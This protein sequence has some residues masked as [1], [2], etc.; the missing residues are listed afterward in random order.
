M[1][2]ADVTSRLAA[3]LAECRRGQAALERQ[4]AQ[5][6]STLAA[7]ETQIALLMEQL[8]ATGQALE[9]TARRAMMAERANAA[10]EASLGLARSE[11]AM[12]RPERDA[13]RRAAWALTQQL[14]ALEGALATGWL[15]R[16]PARPAIGR[17]EGAIALTIALGLRRTEL[18]AV[19]QMVRAQAARTPLL[20]V[21]DRDL[22]ASLDPAPAAWLRLPSRREL[23][24][25]VAPDHRDYLRQRLALLI[26]ALQP[27]SIVPLGAFAAQLLEHDGKRP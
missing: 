19:I 17:P 11:A 7:H 12:L 15:R 22:G 24:R 27:A 21:V 23:P 5:A 16:A 10:A 6:A 26:Q 9:T 20:L 14:G 4:L 8:E 18:P 13:A 3:E 1:S 25:R 2:L